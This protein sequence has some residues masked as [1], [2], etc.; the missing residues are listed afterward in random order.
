M[1]RISLFLTGLFILCGWIG[2]QNDKISFNT[3]DHDFG[4]IGDRDGRVY[5]DFILT[6]NSDEAIVIT[7]ATASCGCTTPIWSKE[8]IEPNKTG[9][10]NVGYSPTGLGSFNKNVSVY[11]NQLPPIPLTIRG[12]VI[13]SSSVPKKLTPEEEYPIAIGAYRLK[14]MELNFDQ[15]DY[16]EK[17]TLRL[18]VFNN[19]DKPIT[20]KALKLPKY[21]KVDISAPVIP[22]KTQ[23]VIDVHLEIQDINL[24]GYLLGDFNLQ[25]D[26]IPHSFHYSAVVQDNFSKWTASKRANAGKIN[27]NTAEI[28]F[29]NLSSGNSR[30]IKISNS[31]RTA[32]NIRNI[33]SFD[34]SISVSNPRF[35]INPGEIAEIKVIIDNRKIQSNN[36]SSTLAIITDDP[37]KPIYE[38]VVTA[39]KRL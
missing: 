20:Q 18:E 7:R 13:R 34:P 27:V 8:P 9:T 5:F 38:I 21:I 4:T 35:I 16:L 2:A 23:A 32:L 30:T 17:K 37:K 3:T 6:N 29:G 1:K 10:I 11:I 33:Q 15:I 36:L 25:I 22:P 39:S 19:S 24:Y 31:G 14:S 26:G 28:N 12:E